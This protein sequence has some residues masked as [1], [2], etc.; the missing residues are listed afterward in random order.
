MSETTT[1]R[2]WAMVHHERPFTEN[3]LRKHHWSWRAARTKEWR[4][5]FFWLAKEQHVPHLEQARAVVTHYVGNG[6]WPDTAACLPAAKAGIDGL[7]DAG[8]LD[9][10]DP[11][12]L[13]GIKFDVIT[14]PL[15]W[16]K[17]GVSGALGIVIEE[18]LE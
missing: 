5:V 13:V 11:A 2:R 9:D 10:D 3:E 12:H 6:H 16:K 18:V 15:L 4:E 14:M 17:S 7:V 1:T 8:M